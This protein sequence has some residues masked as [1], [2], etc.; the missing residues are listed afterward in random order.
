MEEL[1]VQNQQDAFD[2]ALRFYKEGAHSLSVAVLTLDLG[3]PIHVPEGTEMMGYGDND[4][5]I[6]GTIYAD[7]FPG[8]T[9]VM[10]Q[11]PVSSDDKHLACQVGARPIGEQELGGCLLQ[12][13][14][15]TMML[16]N[17]EYRYDPFVDNIN[18]RTLQS[19]SLDA[20]RLLYDCQN[21]PHDDF[22]KVR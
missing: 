17:A 16:G 15:I 18:A 10:F 7:A 1:L 9:Q 2:Q 21:C 6:N 5:V 8:D 13:S 22:L 3:L 19:L 12:H 11:Y 14:N 4:T 20:K